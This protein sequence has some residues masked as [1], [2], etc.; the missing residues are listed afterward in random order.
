MCVH[1]RRPSL[2][3]RV[4]LAG[5]LAIGLILIVSAAF[6][7]WGATLVIPALAM[8]VEI[9]VGGMLTIGAALGLVAPHRAGR[10]IS[11]QWLLDELGMWL[12]AGG[13]ATYTTAALLTAP[14]AFVH[15]MISLTFCAS[16]VTRLATIRT[17]RA[18]IEAAVERYER[19]H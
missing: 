19:G 2:F 12:A 1:D 8:W 9:V 3:V 5:W 15:W 14:A 13:W 4:T 10:I 17:E 18:K 6:P 7:A 16:A 11:Q